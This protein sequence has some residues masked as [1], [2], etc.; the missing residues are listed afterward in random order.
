MILNSMRD[1]TP[2]ALLEAS[3]ISAQRTGASAALAA[4]LL[5]GDRQPDGLALLGLGPINLEVLRYTA[6]RLPSLNRIV[7]H[8]PDRERAEGFAAEVAEVLPD[9]RVSLAGTPAEAM[10]SAPI[11]SLATNA[12]AP[13]IDLTVCQPGATVLHVSLRD[14]TVPAIIYAQN[15]VDDADHV[16]RER[17]SLHL[18]ELQAGGRDFIDAEI[19]A[20]LRGASAWRRDPERTAVFS[21]FGLGVLDLAVARWVRERA[22]RGGLGVRVDGFLPGVPDHAVPTPAR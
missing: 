12:A 22:E 19:G 6:V 21:P 11:I 14:L 9:A 1:G 5:A 17:T 3:L 16:C 4:G 13:H 20:V 7:L 2:E 18:A 15:L 10:A 8:D